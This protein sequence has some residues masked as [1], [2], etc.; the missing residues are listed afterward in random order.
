LSKKAT[1]I[2][3]PE[4][5]DIDVVPISQFEIVEGLIAEGIKSI[6]E[7]LD[8]LFFNP[9]DMDPT[10]NALA[11]RAI[12]LTETNGLESALSAGQIGMHKKHKMCIPIL[13]NMQKRLENNAPEGDKIGDMDLGVF[14]QDIVDFLTAMHKVMS[15]GTSDRS[16]RSYQK[17]FTS[18]K[19]LPKV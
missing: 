18:H 19:P 11:T 3:R 13:R 8:V 10:L 2:E 15:D 5:L 7:S 16:R 9:G 14:G 4:D 12:A 17:A 6:K 1:R